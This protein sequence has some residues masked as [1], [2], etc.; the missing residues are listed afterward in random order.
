[1]FKTSRVWVSR[2][3]SSFSSMSSSS[4]SSSN[5]SSG[6]RN[7]GGSTGSRHGGDGEVVVF[8]FGALAAQ[9]TQTPRPMARPH[10]GVAVLVGGQADQVRARIPGTWRDLLHPE[11]RW[12]TLVLY[13]P[14]RAP[15]R[16]EDTKVFAADRDFPVAV[17]QLYNLRDIDLLVCRNLSEHCLL[18]QPHPTA[19]TWV[20]SN[21]PMAEYTDG[22]VL[23]L[24][25][26]V[27]QGI[28]S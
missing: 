18:C 9:G 8:S 15:R 23:S 3:T 27:A 25:A 26:A 22:D 7:R 16:E 17:V 5:S 1:M 12:E 21:G 2:S 13:C 24:E 19:M 6:S 20:G 14:L 10:S 11:A 28:A 4:S